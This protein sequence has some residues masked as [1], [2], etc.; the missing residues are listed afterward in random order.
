MSSRVQLTSVD[1]SGDAAILARRDGVDD[2]GSV[3][4]VLAAAADDHAVTPDGLVRLVTTA[5]PSSL[6][7]TRVRL[8]QLAAIGVVVDAV[9]VTRVPSAKD[10]WPK[11]WAK[12]QRR[13]VA[14]FER[15]CPVPVVTKRLRQHGDPIGGKQPMKRLRRQ[16]EP[17]EIETYG[18]GYRWRV[19]ID[20][21]DAIAE[22][23]VGT[24][25]SVEDGAFLV[26]DL[27]DVQAWRPLPSLL[28]RCTA[29]AA[30]ADDAMIVVDFERNPELWPA[31]ES[32]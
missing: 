22:L 29:T 26:I 30:S 14:A 10:D 24:A 20:A 16:V 27:D 17:P 1:A 8:A 12:A 4:G 11:A 18:D 13:A 28:A 25:G 2:L 23:Q 3:E 32:R 31:G 15:V 6:T 5:D 9:I 7:M 19:P 21:L